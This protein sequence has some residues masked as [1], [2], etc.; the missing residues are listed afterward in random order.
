[1]CNLLELQRLPLLPVLQAAHLAQQWLDRGVERHGK[2]E[3][4]QVE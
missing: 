2:I 1:M 3:P 4:R